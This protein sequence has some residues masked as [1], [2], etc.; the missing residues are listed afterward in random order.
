MNTVWKPEHGQLF[1]AQQLN[2]TD[3]SGQCTED[4]A[5]TCKFSLEKERK[6]GHWDETPLSI[7]HNVKK[8][9][10]KMILKVIFL[11][12]IDHLMTWSTET[13]FSPY[14]KTLISN[15]IHT[16]L[17][18]LYCEQKRQRWGVSIKKCS[19]NYLNK[20]K[21]SWVC[22]GWALYSLGACFN[23]DNQQRA[24]KIQKW[25]LLLLLLLL[26]LCLVNKTPKNRAFCRK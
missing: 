22:S 14:V 8:K 9:L 2:S 11:S 21:I 24:L 3:M 18:V 15:L 25:L 12:I 7:L 19:N 16:Y 4:Q 6:T 17:V 10:P 26:L 23:L 13:I 5:V 1:T 20:E